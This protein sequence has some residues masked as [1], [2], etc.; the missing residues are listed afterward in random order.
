MSRRKGRPSHGALSLHRP[1]PS[2][3]SAYFR[4]T[5]CIRR[6]ML[7][8]STWTPHTTP[9]QDRSHLPLVFGR[10]GLSGT[11]RVDVT[12]T[13]YATQTGRNSDTQFCP[14]GVRSRGGCLSHKLGTSL[15]YVRTPMRSTFASRSRILPHPPT[16]W[17][18]A[19]DG[20]SQNF[21]GELGAAPYVSQFY[22]AAVLCE[23]YLI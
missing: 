4:R 1:T 20:K 23:Y 2:E 6:R 3:L 16:V 12:L 21:I 11:E 9:A 19:M 10:G 14:I 7:Q 18:I 17:R 22:F 15:R 8:A 13:Y 5:T